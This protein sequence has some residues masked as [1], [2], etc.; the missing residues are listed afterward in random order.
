MKYAYTIKKV[1]KRINPTVVPNN[2]ENTSLIIKMFGLIERD[3]MVRSPIEPIRRIISMDTTL[4]N[5]VSPEQILWEFQKYHIDPIID[6]ELMVI[7]LARM[8]SESRVLDMF[9]S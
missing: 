2:C 5:V 7:V 3:N 9:S 8:S 6:R 1:S 4:C